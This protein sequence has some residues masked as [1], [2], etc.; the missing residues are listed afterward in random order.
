MLWWKYLLRIFLK[1]F[2]LW[3]FQVDVTWFYMN[4]LADTCACNRGGDCKCFCT[5]VAAYAQR[6]CHQGVPVDWRSPSLCCK[7]NNREGKK[8]CFHFAI[9]TSVLM[10][11]LTVS[12]VLS[13]AYD[14]EFYNKG[15]CHNYWDLKV[16]YSTFFHPGQWCS[17]VW[18]ITQK[19][20][21]QHI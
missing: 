14:C 8:G 1:L 11:L 15:M 5:S 13:A 21:K 4:C 9:C 19:T 6:C 10:L 7:L 16:P 2:F 3:L 18:L 17:L 12:V 20:Q